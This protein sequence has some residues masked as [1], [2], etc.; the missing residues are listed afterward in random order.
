M[1]SRI[2]CERRGNVEMSD[3]YFVEVFAVLGIFEPI[4]PE[5][6]PFRVG[7]ENHARSANKSELHS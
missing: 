5:S 1:A 4:L 6:L 3:V 2:G 7:L